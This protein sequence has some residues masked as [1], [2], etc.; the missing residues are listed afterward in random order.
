[1][2]VLARR[3]L[4][5]L[6]LDN[7][8]IGLAGAVAA[9]PR[10]IAQRGLRIPDEAAGGVRVAQRGPLVL[11]GRTGGARRHERGRCQHE[12]DGQRSRAQAGDRVSHGSSRI[13]KRRPGP[14]NSPGQK[15]PRPR[16]SMLPAGPFDESGLW[17][18]NE[19]NDQIFRAVTGHRLSTPHPG[20]LLQKV[21]P[22][23]AL[24]SLPKHAEPMSDNGAPP[25][26]SGAAEPR[27]WRGTAR[28]LAY[29]RGCEASSNLAH[30]IVNGFDVSAGQALEYCRRRGPRRR[31]MSRSTRCR[32]RVHVWGSSRFAPAGPGPAGIHGGP[33]LGPRPVHGW[34]GVFMRVVER[35]LIG[36][37]RLRRASAA[38]R[39]A[40]PSPSS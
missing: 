30:D 25:G 9:V 32:E 28:D 16:S 34:V 1:M 24:G 33:A 13:G 6:L 7:A 31:G 38:L 26:S 17:P 12:P 11:I 35:L 36:A 18:P 14:D 2:D 5:E 20:A 15:A 19:L 40:C 10:R 4:L 29:R 22:T 27:R 3:E 39:S 8:G 23:G 21:T 37:C